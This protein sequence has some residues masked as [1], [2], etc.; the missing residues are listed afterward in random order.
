MLSIDIYDGHSQDVNRYVLANMGRDHDHLIIRTDKL[1][2]GYGAIELE[3][4]EIERS[5][6]VSYSIRVLAKL[7]C[8]YR[9]LH[10]EV[11]ASVK[12]L[13]LPENYNQMKNSVKTIAK[14]RGRRGIGNPDIILRAGYSLKILAVLVEL[15]N[16]KMDFQDMIDKM[17]SS[18]ELYQSDYIILVNNARSEYDK[19]KRNAPEAL[20]LEADVKLFREFCVRETNN[21]ISVEKFFQSDYVY[22]SQ[23]IF[24][25]LLK[26]NARRGGEPGKLMLTDWT[27]V[28]NGSCK[29]KEDLER[30]VDPIII[31]IISNFIQD[32]YVNI[33]HFV[34]NIRP[35]KKKDK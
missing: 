25:R 32:K 11:N 16:L 9:E 35:V 26:F 22:L 23:L 2:M 14:Y 10:D 20:T 15:E 33:L 12:D 13:V 6:N 1:L 34:T 24:I 17:R 21:L 19:R 18:A 29:R 30:L 5:H 3:K 4:K 27:M 7:L 31:I 8:A 28:E